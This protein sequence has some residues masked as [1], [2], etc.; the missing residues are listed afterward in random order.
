MLNLMGKQKRFT[1]KIGEHNYIKMGEMSYLV[2][3]MFVFVK[4]GIMFYFSLN[5]V[6]FI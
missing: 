2:G 6:H 1:I 5:N 4:A 3:M